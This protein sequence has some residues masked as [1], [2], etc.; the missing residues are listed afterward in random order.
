A[1]PPCFLGWRAASAANEW[2]DAA[3]M[4]QISYYVNCVFIRGRLV[5]NRSSAGK[6][7]QG[8]N[9]PVYL[10]LRIV[11]NEAN[12][13]QSATLQEAQSLHHRQRIIVPVPDENTLLAQ[14]CC[15]LCRTVPFQADSKSWSAFV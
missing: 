1:P 2:N 12:A 8:L 6:L 14:T 15:H 4:A 11:V 3:I 9:N 10:S 7:A 5:I 13:H